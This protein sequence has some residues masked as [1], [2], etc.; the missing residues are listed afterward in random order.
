MKI[1]K[2]HAHY[3]RIPFDMGAPRTEF[4]GLRFPTMDH[5][6]VEVETDAG[7]TGY[8]EGFGHSIIPATQAALASYVA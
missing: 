4:A 3:V 2:I 5:L 6:L 8:G 7:I 1:T